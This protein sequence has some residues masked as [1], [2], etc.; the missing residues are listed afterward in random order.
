LWQTKGVSNAIIHDGP[1]YD[2]SCNRCGE[3]YYAVDTSAEE[4]SPE[5][6]ASHRCRFCNSKDVDVQV[7][8]DAYYAAQP[9]VDERDF[10]VVKN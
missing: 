6:V 7:M 4:V 5:K 9:S 8:D 2:V 10:H 1:Y 3:N